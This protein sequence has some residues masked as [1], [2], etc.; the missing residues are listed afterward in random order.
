MY[1]DTVLRLSFYGNFVLR[2]AKEYLLRALRQISSTDIVSMDTQVLTAGGSFTFRPKFI[3]SYANKREYRQCT[4]S[5][6]CVVFLA[7][8]R[9]CVV[10]LAYYRGVCGVFGIIP[11]FL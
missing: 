10:F 4:K 9:L 11:K 8:Y 5:R 2:T 7:Y 6:V 1:G 3:A